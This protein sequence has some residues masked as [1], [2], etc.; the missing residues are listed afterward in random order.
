MKPA[1]TTCELWPL[2]CVKAIPSCWRVWVELEKLL[3]L[4]SLQLLLATT[5]SWVFPVFLLLLFALSFPCVLLLSFSLTQNRH[6]KNTFRR[7]SWFENIAWHIYLYRSSWWVCLAT[8]GTHSGRSRRTMDLDRGYWFGSRGSA[9]SF[10]SSPW[11]E[12]VVYSRPRRSGWGGEW[13]PVVCHSNSLWLEYDF[14][15][16]ILYVFL[17]CLQFLFCV[18]PVFPVRFCFCSSPRGYVLFQNCE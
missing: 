11:D 15:W 18:G 5:I 13:I 9:I 4:Q 6:Y 17:F 10:D 16:S 14:S 12:E 2:L 1:R 8:W 3:S 7:S